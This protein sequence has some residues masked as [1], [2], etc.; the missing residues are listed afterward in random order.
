MRVYIYI[1]IYIIDLKNKISKY[2]NSISLRKRKKKKKIIDQMIE[3]NVLGKKKKK[4][5]EFSKWKGLLFSDW[6]DND[7]IIMMIINSNNNDFL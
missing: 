5:T 4:R 1:H 3:V 7:N 2:L 6:V